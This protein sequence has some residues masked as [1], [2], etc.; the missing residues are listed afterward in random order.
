MVITKIIKKWAAPFTIINF[1]IVCKNL[2][3]FDLNIFFEYKNYH[4]FFQKLIKHAF[5]YIFI[6]FLYKKHF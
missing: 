4:E 2:N 1:N 3:V 5:Y 6:I